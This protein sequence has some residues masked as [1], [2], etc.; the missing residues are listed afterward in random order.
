VNSLPNENIFL[1]SWTLAQTQ[2][3]SSASIRLL[4]PPVAVVE[5]VP[6]SLGPLERDP[7]LGLDEEQS[8]HLRK[9]LLL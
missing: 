3:F 5:D 7:K 9:E 6:L 1:G 4:P 2:T 8:A